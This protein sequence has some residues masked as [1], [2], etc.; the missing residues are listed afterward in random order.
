MG[1]TVGFQCCVWD[2][3]NPGM[4]GTP[5]D[6]QGLGNVPVRQSKVLA[7]L[8]ITHYSI[9]PVHEPCEQ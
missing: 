8:D 4:P 2:T 7:N 6:S 3:G 1:R 9:L 5:L